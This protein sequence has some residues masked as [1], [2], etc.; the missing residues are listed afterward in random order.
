VSE[1]LGNV[2]ALPPV[3]TPGKFLRTNGGF[4]S[5]WAQIT[6]SDVVGLSTTVLQTWRFS[7]GSGAP[8]TGRVTLN[9]PAWNNV[10]QINLSEMTYTGV[11]WSNIFDNAKV[12]DQFAIQDADNAS[13]IGRYTISAA[14]SDQGGYRVFTVTCDSFSGVEPSNN[15]DTRIAFTSYGPGGASAP[16]STFTLPPELATP[17]PAITDFN[18][19][20]N[21][22]WYRPQP[23]AVNGPPG[24]A[25]YGLLFHQDW[26]GDN[27]HAFQLFYPMYTHELWMRMAIT[28]V[29]Q[30]WVKVAPIDSGNLPP[31]LASTAS[32]TNDWNT[33]TASGFYRGGGAANAPGD[34]G[35]NY[36]MG[37]VSVYD[38]G[39]G[40]VGQLLI[41]LF[42]DAIWFRRQ[43]SGAWGSWHKLYPTTVTDGGL[44][45]RL[46]PYGAN[47]IA[48]CN[49]QLASG[50]GY[51]QAGQSANTPYGASAASGPWGVLET[52]MMNG[53]DNGIQ[54]WWMYTTENRYQRSRS[55]GVW[56]AWSSSWPVSDAGL[57]G[58]IMAGAF[59]AAQTPDANQALQSG[60]YSSPPGNP[61]NPT[62]GAHYLLWVNAGNSDYVTQLASS[63]YTNE[64]WSRRGGASS[65]FGAWVQVFPVGDQALPPRLATVGPQIPSND[66]NLAVNNGWYCAIPG[67]ANSPLGI[68]DYWAVEV[69][70]ITYTAACRQI[71][72]RHAT[73]Q[74]Y[75]RFQNSGN[76]SAWTL[77]AGGDA[78]W[79]SL[80]YANSWTPYA[81]PY[82][83]ARYRKLASGLVTFNG[84]IFKI[85]AGNTVN[86]GEVM[87]QVSPGYRP[88]QIVLVTCPCYQSS[89]IRLNFQVDGTVQADTQFGGGVFDPSG[90]VSLAG[91]S[92]YA[93]Q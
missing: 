40:H 71:A 43:A 63:L 51:T 50:W 8:S 62:S 46:Q 23:G 61:N 15:S 30:P 55:N 58:R 60:W 53:T 86:S 72:Y 27:G 17:S 41:G 16:P 77:A 70:N 9:A 36:F 87:F 14:P 24:T 34:A 20:R 47:F 91:V 80:S 85:G 12:G 38:A 37:F 57:P 11:D 78:A 90:W 59:T 81:S 19:S 26:T 89:F 13:N 64:L 68:S 3:D 76:W 7:T 31:W 44:P 66:F 29:W 10:T 4:G 48:D 32:A 56:G 35:Y 92:Y 52:V 88:N 65:G 73:L 49:T 6:A 21:T 33:A 69:L 93:D 67:S 54:R 1:A 84:L 79:Q 39:G 18:G 42:D 82:G 83:P 28:Y 22:G 25:E 5:E 45:P 74:T 75:E 2:R